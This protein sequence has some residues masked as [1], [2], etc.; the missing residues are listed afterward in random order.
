MKNE[1]SDKYSRKGYITFQTIKVSELLDSGK[2]NLAKK[3][4]FELLKY[5]PYDVMV[6]IQLATILIFEKEYETAKTVLEGLPEEYVF[7][8]LA[9]LY[10]KLGEDDKLFELYNRYY[11]EGVVDEFDYDSLSYNRL[12]IYLRKKYDPNYHLD[13]TSIIY[14]DSQ[15]FDYNDDRAINHIKKHH[16]FNSID[17]KGKFSDYIDIDSL[18]YDI[19]GSIDN[20]K[21]KSNLKRNVIDNY[22]F[23]LPNCGFQNEVA[24][25]YVEVITL[26]NSPN[27]ITMYPAK[28]LGY[29]EV[30]YLDEKKE[31]KA[32]VKVKTGLE[33]FQSK[34]GKIDR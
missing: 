26:I 6:N 20:N 30:C 13:I 16:S 10:I 9:N 14:S 31:E 15:I 7:N 24:C 1:V 19:K 29:G 3:I 23:Y 17:D 27:I 11:K 25:N 2:I 22:L 32:P 33:R 12:K 34:Y 8:K 21:N 18:F 5:Y 4:I 28:F